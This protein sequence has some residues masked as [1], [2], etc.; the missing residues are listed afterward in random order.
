MISKKFIVKN[1]NIL[2]ENELKYVDMLVENGQI[3]AL[4][5]NLQEDAQ[6]DVEVLDAKGKII[7]PGF[8]D[9]HTHGGAG[10]DMNKCDSEGLRKVSEFFASCGT[11]TFLPTILTDSKEVLLQCIKN[12]VEGM[13]SV[14]SGASIY[15]IHMEG[16]YL[17]KEYK[18]AMPEEFLQLPSIEDFKEYQ[19]AAENTIRLITVSPEVE[20]V[21]AFIKEV[22][23]SGVRVSIGHSG[24]DYEAAMACIE[25]GANGATHTFNAMKLMHQHF[26][27]ISGAVLESDI[28][29]EAIC[30]G[31][32]LVPAIVRLLIKVKGI[33]RVIAVTDSIMAAGLGDG[34]YKLGV[35]DIV[36]IDGDAKL[37]DL[38]A[39]AG[40]TLTTNQALKNLIEFT[41]RP[42][43]EISKVLS[44]NP[45]DYL[46]I[47]HYKG[48]IK[49]GYDADFIVL[50]ADYTVKQ[51]FVQGQRVFGNEEI[52]S[53]KK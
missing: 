52:Y 30:D 43:E 19:E 27:S 21:S 7:I 12:I 24:A 46:G 50:D 23:K 14:K 10:V 1:A 53:P 2:V 31:R 15:G 16:P 48:I 36:V 49:V 37:A 38:S 9:I 18:G 8:I 26:P 42:V 44:K 28:Y 33:D 45:A 51:T 20:G 25:N 4:E 41:G 35:N 11:T 6:E 34:K 40:S 5:K 29:C 13:K 3:I 47:G 22:T 39:R 32:H 17:C